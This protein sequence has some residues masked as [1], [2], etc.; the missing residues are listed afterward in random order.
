ML[1]SGVVELRFARFDTIAHCN[2]VGRAGMAVVRSRFVGRLA[3][4]VENWK[5]TDVVASR[6]N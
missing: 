6:R 2:R 5:L 3:P 4:Y 1:P